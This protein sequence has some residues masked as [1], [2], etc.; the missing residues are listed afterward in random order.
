MQVSLQLTQ[1]L[2]G[3][4]PLLLCRLLGPFQRL[5]L[6]LQHRQFLFCRLLVGMLK[7]L[8]HAGQLAFQRG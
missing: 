6:A 7:L 2:S 1:G 3:L 8:L 5:Q 4:I